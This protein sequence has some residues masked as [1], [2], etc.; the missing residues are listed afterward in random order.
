MYCVQDKLQRN[1]NGF[2]PIFEQVCGSEETQKKAKGVLHDVQ[3]GCY[4]STG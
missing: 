3:K 1:F 4:N 2:L